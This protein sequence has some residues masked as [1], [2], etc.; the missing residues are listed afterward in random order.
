MEEN[1]GK[2]SENRGSSNNTQQSLFFIK[3]GVK[4]RKDQALKIRLDTLIKQ[5][6]MS[7]RQFY[8]KLEISRQ[9]W[10]AYSWGFWEMPIYLKIKVS[11]LLNTD[12]SL[13]FQE[14][15]NG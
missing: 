8:R 5:A 6:G 14:E 15:K 2:V 12:T 4:K 11:K 1:K 3:H 7:Q 9:A 13:I 10:Y